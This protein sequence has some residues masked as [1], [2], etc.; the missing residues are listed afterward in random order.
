MYTYRN[1]F[2]QGKSMRSLHLNSHYYILFKNVRDTN[3]IGVLSRQTGLKHLLEAYR[4]VTSVPF[5]PLILDMKT[6]C[7]DYLRVRSHVLPG[8]EM[9]VH[10][11]PRDP[12]LPQACLRR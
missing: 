7:I 4:K 1:L 11:N 2:D 6:D 3:Q 5:T 10:V 12:S 9:R 8:E